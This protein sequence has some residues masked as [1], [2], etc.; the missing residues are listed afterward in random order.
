[1][2]LT[3]GAMSQNDESASEWQLDYFGLLL[4]QERW[5]FTLE[6]TLIPDMNFRFPSIYICKMPPP[7]V[8]GGGWGAMCVGAHGGQKKGGSRITQSWN[9]RWL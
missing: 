4:S 8:W 5:L 6:L 1:M 3:Y 2:N 9:F 7:S